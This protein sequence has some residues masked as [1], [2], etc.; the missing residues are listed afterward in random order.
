M[1]TSR[2][3]AVSS[4]DVPSIPTLRGRAIEQMDRQEKG[5][6]LES[7]VSGDLTPAAGGAWTPIGPLTLPNGVGVST[8]P[9]QRSRHRHCHRSDEFAEGLSRHGAGRRVALAG[10]RH[11]LDFDFRQCANDGDWRAGGCAFEARARFTSAPANSIRAVIVSLASGFIAST[12]PTLRRAL[13]GPINP[14]QTIGNLTYNV[15]NGRSITKILV[16]PTDPATIWV[17]TARGVGGSGANAL[18]HDPSAGA[19]RS[20]SII[21]RNFV[22]PYFSKTDCQPGQQCLTRPATGNADV[23]DMVMEPGTPDNI[24]VAVIGLTSQNGGIYRVDERH[25]RDADV[26]SDE[27]SRNYRSHQFGD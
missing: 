6:R 15:F 25:H 13:V 21:E 3:N 10:W 8:W 17:S 20:V 24:L 11:D 5:R 22:K 4:P 16:H 1:S 14:Q 19:A 9:N 23:V 26:H 18:G 27:T 7:I 2:A 12:T